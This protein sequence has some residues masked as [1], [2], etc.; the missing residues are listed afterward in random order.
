MKKTIALFGL[1][2]A[3]QGYANAQT[4]QETPQMNAQQ[5]AYYNH[6]L[7]TD[8]ARRATVQEFLKAHPEVKAE[9]ARANGTKAYLHHIDA[10]GQ[11][12]Y[13]ASHSN[14]GLATSIKTTK[15]WA[16]GGLGLSLNGSGMEV[17]ATRSRLGMWEPGPTRTSHQEFSGRAIQRDLPVFTTSDGNT[18]HAAHVAGTMIGAGVDAQA[19]GM[20]WGAKLDCYESQTNEL[21]EILQAGSEGMLVSNHSYGPTFSA[22]S[23]QPHGYYDQECR[24]YDSLAVSNKYHLMVVAAGNDRDESNNVKYDILVGG[25]IAKN[26]L[27]IAAVDILGTGGYTGPGSVNMSDFS[28]F[29]PTDDGRVKPDVSVPGV[30]IYSAYSGSDNAYNKSDGTSMAAPGAAGSLFLLQQE[31]KALHNSFM[32]SA[33]LKGLAI[34]AADEAGA[35]DGPDYAY[36][37]GLLNMEKAVNVMRNDG[38]TYFMSEATL[39]NGTPY[40]KYFSTAGGTFKAT[41]SW[42]DGAGHPVAGNPTNNRTPMLINDL[43]LRVMDSATGAAISTLPWKLDPANPSAA[44]THGDNTVDNVEQIYVSNL[45]AGKYYIQV[46]NKGSLQGGSQ[47]FA[48]MASG[49]TAAAT[50]VNSYGNN[51]GAIM[52]APVPSSSFVTIANTASVLNGT[53]AIITD[54]QGRTVAS[55]TLQARQQIDMRTWSDGIYSLRLTDGTVMRIVKH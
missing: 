25:A 1:M 17:S 34:H 9:L 50:G 53:P 36:G 48:V 15:L 11:P 45:P 21:A 46:T 22:T 47:D 33:T 40:K 49:V 38:N 4:S 55:F 27:S 24:D 32:R 52:V 26:V 6:L 44:A 2:L 13:Y 12:V 19:K 5:R 37:W 41:I 31:Y 39:N 8:A 42:T 35:A 3:A 18:D 14:L 28:S 29:G 43:D 54:L 10:D 16:G 23:T 20:A 30:Q 51:G 7:S